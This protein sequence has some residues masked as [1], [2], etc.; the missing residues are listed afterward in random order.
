MLEVHEESRDLVAA[1]HV[2]REWRTALISAPHFWT[3]IDFKNPERANCYLE[4]SKL[5]PIDVIVRDI[6]EEKLDPIT[7]LER[8]KSLCIEGDPKTITKF[9]EQLFQNTPSK[10]QSLQIL[11]PSSSTQPFVLPRNLLGNAPSL[12]A[13]VFQRVS[14]STFSTFSL[15]KLTSIDWYDPLEETSR[16]KLEDLLELFESLPL[17]EVIKVYVPKLTGNPLKKVSLK[18]LREF[19]WMGLKSLAPYIIAPKLTR[20]TIR[21]H[22]RQITP[23]PILPPDIPL[24]FEPT[25]IVYQCSFDQDWLL[26]YPTD[27]HKLHL[28]KPLS[29]EN[30][31]DS[32][33]HLDR[34]ISFLKVQELEIVSTVGPGSLLVN[35]PIERFENLDKL[36]LE[37]D[38]E[39]LL[40][41]LGG[42]PVP[43]TRLSKIIYT[44]GSDTNNCLFDPG[45]LRNVLLRRKKAG[46]KVKTLCI[47]GFKVADQDI[48]ALKE[49]VGEVNQSSEGT[50][51][52]TKKPSFR[53]FLH[54][55]QLRYVLAYLKR[56][57]PRLI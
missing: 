18:H 54:L 37:G 24:L 6:T 31:S 39:S 45:T 30:S 43:C 35:F 15:P 51:S 50:L 27:G 2:C 28:I 44:S 25:T 33:S 48:E 46:Y 29:L 36:R 52:T 4:R 8:M 32:F 38:V 26:C 47:S 3:K 1:T 21:S 40:P 10:L 20:L 57:C 34:Q 5:A 13:L 53:T 23:L 14:P 16:I 42:E 41:T 17:V 55:F 22:H 7:W 49:V 56:L 19:E 9:A 12:Q 11:R